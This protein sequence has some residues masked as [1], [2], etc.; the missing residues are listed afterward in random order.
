LEDAAAA[1]KAAQS[2]VEAFLNGAKLVDELLRPMSD[3]VLGLGQVP[4]EDADLIVHVA[5]LCA[6]LLGHIHRI[7]S[8]RGK[9]KPLGG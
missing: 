5:Q 3:I 8:L 9:R 7:L 1:G 2:A 4:F 6:V